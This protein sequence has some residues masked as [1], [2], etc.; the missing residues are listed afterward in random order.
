MMC[1]Y[2]NLWHCLHIEK[3]RVSI[4]NKTFSNQFMCHEKEIGTSGNLKPNEFECHY[5]M[6]F[7]VAIY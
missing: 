6:C 2:R 3:K 7:C 1:H 5:L 4:E